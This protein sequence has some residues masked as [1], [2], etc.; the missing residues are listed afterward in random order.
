MA[1]GQLKTAIR[2][3]HELWSHR[4][5]DGVEQCNQRFHGLFRLP[6]RGQNLLHEHIT[7]ASFR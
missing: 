5:Q 4:P 3:T 1:P 6:V 7:E 2:N